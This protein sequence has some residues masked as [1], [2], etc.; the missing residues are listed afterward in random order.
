MQ[1]FVLKYTKNSG[2]RDPRTPAAEGETFVRT[3]PHAQAVT[4]T[5]PNPVFKVTAFLKSFIS[6]ILPQF[7]LSVLETKLL[8]NTN[9]KPH[10]VYRMAPLSVTLS[11]L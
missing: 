10:P 2:G 1:D 7:F 6:K 8:K 11:D 5:D 9:R 3:Y 4:L